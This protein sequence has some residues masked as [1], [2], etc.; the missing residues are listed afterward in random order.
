MS[1]AG[2]VILLTGASSGIGA[3]LA[4]YL[5]R[6]GA[7]LSLIGR[8]AD[9]FKKVLS[10][11][12]TN[13]SR[14]QP[15]IIL[16]DVSIDGERIVSE[17][18]NK[19]GKI[20]ILINCAGYG[21]IGSLETMKMEDFDSL[22]ATN[23]RSAIHLSQLSV[24]FLIASKGNI[25]N[26][27]SVVGLRPFAGHIAYS[28]SKS[29]LDQFTKCTALELAPKGVRVNSVN[30]GFIDNEFHINAGIP[31]EQYHSWR[32]QFTK[33]HP[34]GRVGTSSDIVKAATFL[35]NNDL[36]SFVTGVCLPVDGGF[37]IAQ[38]HL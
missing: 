7:L 22:I 34:I 8:N 3:E 9:K 1:F 36:S 31:P 30:P 2:K 24:P 29:A 11:I 28:L 16:A 32:E 35:I 25:L 18:I 12:K 26:V 23:V 33:L 27:S 6:E 14:N 10:D 13:G 15:H 38:P 21:Q 17:T 4:I 20:D 19:F 5:S 37:S